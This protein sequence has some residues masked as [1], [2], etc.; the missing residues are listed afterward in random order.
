VKLTPEK[1]TARLLLAPLTRLAKEIAAE[2]VTKRVRIVAELV[3][4]VGKDPR[5]VVRLYTGTDALN[6]RGPRGEVQPDGTTLLAEAV[7]MAQEK[8]DSLEGAE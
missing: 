6:E 7:A 4:H 1:K 2:A 3:L 8:L 5:L